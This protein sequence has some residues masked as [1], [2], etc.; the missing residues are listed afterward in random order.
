[1]KRLNLDTNYDKKKNIYTLNLIGDNGYNYCF[2]SKNKTEFNFRKDML[3]D[4]IGY[5]ENLPIIIE[6]KELLK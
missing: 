4:V 2:S 6:D 5:Y 1:M 3:I